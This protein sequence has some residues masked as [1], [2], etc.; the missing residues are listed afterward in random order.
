MQ[1]KKAIKKQNIEIL[2]KKFYNTNDSK[3]FFKYGDNYA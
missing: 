2:L 3:L 1:T